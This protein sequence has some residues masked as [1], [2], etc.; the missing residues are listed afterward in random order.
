MIPMG[1]SCRIGFSPP[2]STG[3]HDDGLDRPGAPIYSRA[4]LAGRVII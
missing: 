2:G 1:G 4:L 3:G